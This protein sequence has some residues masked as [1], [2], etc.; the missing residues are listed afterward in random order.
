MRASDEEHL[1]GLDL[2]ERGAEG[3]P[4]FMGGMS[5]VPAE[6]PLAS[7]GNRGRPRPSG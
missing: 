2:T 5:G 4:E 3:Y 6:V 7:P 1:L